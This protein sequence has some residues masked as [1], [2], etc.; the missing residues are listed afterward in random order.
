[1]SRRKSTTAE[2]RDAVPDVRSEKPADSEGK[3]M[4]LRLTQNEFVR[5]ELRKKG[6]YFTFPQ[7]VARRRLATQQFW[8]IL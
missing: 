2:T 3:D 6:E 5:G 4:I 8:E 1:M 7:S